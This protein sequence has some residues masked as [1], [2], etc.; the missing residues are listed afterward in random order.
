MLAR[1][2]QAAEAEDVPRCE[3]PSVADV[4]AGLAQVLTTRLGSRSAAGIEIHDQGPTW[5]IEVLGHASTYSDPS[6]DCAERGRVA[7][8]FAALILEPLEGDLPAGL[9]GRDEKKAPA[10]EVGPY[11]LAVAP[12]FVWTAGAQGHSTPVGL[13][14]QARLGV[15]GRRFGFSFGG[16]AAAFSKLDLGRYGASFSRAAFDLSARVSWRMGWLGLSADLGPYLAF[17]RV[18][19]SGLSEGA[20]ST[21]AD[22]G[23]RGAILARLLPLRLSPFVALQAHAGIRQ[24]DLAVDPSGNIGRAPLVWVGLLLGGVWDW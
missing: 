16:E 17:L 13:G 21:H 4:E 9:S 6:R 15:S 20:T 3:C 12:L 24:F 5:T 18:S 8:V 10:R 11:S 19:G 14:G 1:S 23:A 7:V 2:S 22:A